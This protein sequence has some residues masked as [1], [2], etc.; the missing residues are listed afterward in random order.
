MIVTMMAISLS[1]TLITTHTTNGVFDN[2]PAR[3]EGGIISPILWWAGLA[4]GFL[5]WTKA[6]RVPVSN[7]LIG[8][9]AHCTYLVRQVIQN[10]R[11]VEQSDIS[12][13]A[14]ER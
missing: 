9:V 12:G 5:A 4:F 1:D 13:R 3:G 14:R 7:A 11:L 6:A 10:P 8:R 2:N